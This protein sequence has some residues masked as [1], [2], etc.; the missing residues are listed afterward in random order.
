MILHE[1][2]FFTAMPSIAW[3]NQEVKLKNLDF[4][5]NIERK[6]PFEKRQAAKRHC[7]RKHPFTASFNL[8]SEKPANEQG[9]SVPHLN[10]VPI[11]IRL[12]NV[13]THFVLYTFRFSS[14]YMI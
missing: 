6:E 13:T 10:A 12:K 5:S 9:R 8:I 4:R 2:W 7:L 1:R 14:D 3:F 11:H